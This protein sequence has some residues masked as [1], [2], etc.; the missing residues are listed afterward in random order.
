M[1]EVSGRRGF[2]RSPM[3]GAGLFDVRVLGARAA[4]S[5]P[6]GG[7]GSDPAA[8]GGW[9]RDVGGSE[10]WVQRDVVQ[11][12]PIAA[13][14]CAVLA[15]RVFRIWEIRQRGLGVSGRFLEAK[16]W[17]A[18]CNIRMQRSN[19]NCAPRSHGGPTLPPP[20]L[21]PRAFSK[22]HRASGLGGF[23]LFVPSLEG[24]LGS[25]QR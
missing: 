7:R 10:I 9:R 17:H 19:E 20:S 6:S 14:V 3:F 5:P 11:K 25:T 18:M 8:R 15:R 4:I 22:T 16:N 23:R 1:S 13:P 24:C 12:D 2:R 21:D